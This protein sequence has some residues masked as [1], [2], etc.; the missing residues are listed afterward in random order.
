M[1]HD[2]RMFF[3]EPFQCLDYLGL[4]IRPRSQH[5][6]L[7]RSLQTLSECFESFFTTHA[8]PRLYAVSVHQPVNHEISFARILFESLTKSPSNC[9]HSDHRTDFGAF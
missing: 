5:I 9:A 8:I 6:R 2:K 3:A 4:G 1:G 7:I